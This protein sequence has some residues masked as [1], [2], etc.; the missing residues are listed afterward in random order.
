MK[1]L[2]N[3]W[4]TRYN[5]FGV[6]ATTKQ[7]IRIDS[8]DDLNGLYQDGFFNQPYYL[9]SG[10]SNSL[11][12]Q[13]HYE[14]PFLYMK[15]RKKIVDSGDEGIHCFGAG[16]NWDAIVDRQVKNGWGGGLKIYP[17]FRGVWARHPFRT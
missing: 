11:L 3:S 6:R 16:E 17:L 12:L 14:E 2:S 13:N 7:L 9:L 15:I 8:A 1:A 5:T 10:G 4:L